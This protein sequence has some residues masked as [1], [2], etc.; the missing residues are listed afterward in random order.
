MTVAKARGD[1]EE[2]LE[3]MRPRS[4]VAAV[5]L[6]AN[7]RLSAPPRR[8][9]AATPP[10]IPTRW[11]RAFQPRRL[12]TSGSDLSRTFH[13]Q[14]RRQSEGRGEFGGG[15]YPSANSTPICPG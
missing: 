10:E 15:I 7:S 6:A 8:S 2:E 13:Q 5:P 12:V 4:T 3:A 9:A 11:L 14:A 1:G